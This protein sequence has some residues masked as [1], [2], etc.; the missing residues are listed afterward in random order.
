MSKQLIPDYVGHL[1]V[2][3]YMNRSNNPI[4]R[5][6]KIRKGMAGHNWRGGLKRNTVNVTDI[7]K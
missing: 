5:D 7:R 4:S 6:L 1:D 2:V 3:A